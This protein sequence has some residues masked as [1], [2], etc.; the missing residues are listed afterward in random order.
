M[1]HVA[2]SNDSAFGVEL[3]YGIWTVPDAVLAPD[4]CL[5]RVQ[6]D[7]G[8]GILLI[9]IDRATAETVCGKT[10]VAPHGEIVARGIGPYAS[11]DLPDA[12]PTNICRVAVLFVAGD[13]TG[14]TADAFRHVKVKAVLLAVSKWSLRNERQWNYFARVFSRADT[15]TVLRQSH[16]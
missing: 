15:E 5:G 6:D 14:A 8:C 13:L 11:F 4:A 12:S 7:A 16:D 9:S 3:R 10:V 1:A 2:F